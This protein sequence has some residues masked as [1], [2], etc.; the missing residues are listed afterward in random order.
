MA[1]KHAGFLED[2]GIRLKKR[3]R[4]LVRKGPPEMLQSCRRGGARL[5]GEWLH[6]FEPSLLVIDEAAISFQ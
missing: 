1:L 3:V 5:F 6:D 2:F 4:R